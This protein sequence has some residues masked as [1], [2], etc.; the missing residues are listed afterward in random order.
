[1]KR[2]EVII[3]TYD[4]HAVAEALTVEGVRG[5]TVTTGEGFGVERGFRPDEKPKP[6]QFRFHPKY[7]VE[8][9][10]LNEDVERVIDSIIAALK[11]HEMGQGKIFVSSVDDAVR[12]RT[13]E[14]GRAAIE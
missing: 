7:K 10:V 5:M 11:F 3:Q 6:E 4:I 9:V 1:M 12:T 2:V 14:R 13:G 8:M